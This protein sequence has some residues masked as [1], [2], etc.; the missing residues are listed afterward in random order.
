MRFERSH[1]FFHQQ[2]GRKV[3][4]CGRQIET[5]V[6][7]YVRLDVC[8]SILMKQYKEKQIQIVQKKRKVN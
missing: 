1:F 4:K 7:V 3:E 2:H 8:E 5:Q 6:C